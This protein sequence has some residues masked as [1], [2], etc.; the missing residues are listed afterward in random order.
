MAKGGQESECAP[1]RLRV[2]PAFSG[3]GTLSIILPV[4]REHRK[5]GC[6]QC[7]KIVSPRLQFLYHVFERW[8]VLC[9]LR[10]V[11]QRVLVLC[12]NRSRTPEPCRLIL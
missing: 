6:A 11:I 10:E 2:M 12:R 8:G 3:T 5:R 1:V 7:L 9:E 4:G